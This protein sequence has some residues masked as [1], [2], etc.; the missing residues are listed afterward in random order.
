MLY[1]QC[2]RSNKFIF[3]CITLPLCSL[4]FFMTGCGQ[5]FYQITEHGHQFRATDVKLVKKGMSQDNVR[6][7][8]GTPT[9]VSRFQKGQAYYY[10]SSTARQVAFFDPQEIDRKIFAIYFNNNG[11]VG[12]VANYGF[13]DGRIFDFVTR[14]TPAANN[15][16][17]GLLSQM[18]KN[19]G[20]RGSVFG[21]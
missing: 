2:K 9:V 21:R 4:I 11:S 6:M 5:S 17:E 14:T 1:T 18:F 13:K 16:E 3:F 19:L 15:N 8:L 12:R 7:L 10:I 20:K